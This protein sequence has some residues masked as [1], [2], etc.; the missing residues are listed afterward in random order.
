MITSVQNRVRL[1]GDR[2]GPSAIVLCAGLRASC[3]R[4]SN[5]PACAA[6]QLHQVH[7][8]LETGEAATFIVTTVLT[9]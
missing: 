2:S 5:S 6:Y 3:Q 9:P 7:I 8:S 4:R 1:V